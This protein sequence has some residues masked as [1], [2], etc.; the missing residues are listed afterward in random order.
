MILLTASIG[1]E[2]IQAVMPP[3]SLQ[4]RLYFEPVHRISKQEET[5]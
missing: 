1:L 3:D 5:L 2:P 4:N